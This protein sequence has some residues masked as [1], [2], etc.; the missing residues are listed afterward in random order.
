VVDIGY[1]SVR[2]SKAEKIPLY[3]YKITLPMY[4]PVGISVSSVLLAQ[5][6][7]FMTQVILNY[8]ACLFLSQRYGRV[9]TE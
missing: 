5:S 6:T 4:P 2:I 8:T 1:A 3:I 9:Y 7:I